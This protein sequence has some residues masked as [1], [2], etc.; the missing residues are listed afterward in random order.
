MKFPWGRIFLAKRNKGLSL[1]HFIKDDTQLKRLTDSFKKKDISLS[2][3]ESRFIEEKK[4]FSRYFEGEKEDFTSL[5]LDFTSG[6]PFQ[7][8]V[9]QEARKIPYGQT[10]SYKFLAERLNHKGYRSVGQAMGQNPLL[11]I[12]PCHR[13]I[14]SD[15][16]LG[17]FS[18]G[19]ELKKFLLRLEGISLGVRP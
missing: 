3:D 15:G 1:A 9:W 5:S 7:K 17:G 12:I 19:L 10:R 13:V 2:L 11:I 16:T 14:S 18:A 8:K 6:T 4:L